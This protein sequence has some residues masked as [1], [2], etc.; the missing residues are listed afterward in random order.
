MDTLTELKK[1]LS[2]LLDIEDHE[3]TPETYLVRELGAESIDMMELAVLM[4]ST[5]NINV[6]D[7]EVFLTRLRPYIIEAEKL[8]K[9]VPLFL[10]E[11]LPF[12]EEDRIKELLKDIEFGPAIKIKDLMSYIE[13]AKKNE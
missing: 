1:I 9:E 7:N 12:L 8:E 6:D 13:W 10:K 2:E 3:I 5:F 4:D 11:K